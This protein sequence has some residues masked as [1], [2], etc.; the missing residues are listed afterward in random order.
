MRQTITT[1]SAL[2]LSVGILLTGS[3]LQ[4]TLLAVRGNLE[5]FPPSMIG[6]MMSGYFA[7]F[8]AGCVVGPLIVRRV[9][10]I[11]A[12]SVF[13]AI[14]ASVI[15]LHALVVDP[16]VWTGLRVI[17]GISLAGL[18]MI[19]ESWLNERSPNELRGSV[20][21]I[22]RIV[23]LTATTGGLL[24]LTLGDPEDYP[25][26]CLGAIL[27]CLALVPVGLTRS[28][29]PAP[30]STVKIRIGRLYRLSPLGVVGCFGFGVVSGAF[31]GMGPVF[32]QAGGVPLSGVAIFMAAVMIGG[33]LAQ[34]PVGWL[35][36]RY[37]R[38]TILAGTVF[39]ASLS[40]LILIGLYGMPP[41][42]LLVGSA[43]FG[44]LMIPVYSL[45]IS[46]ANDYMEPGDFVEASS[47]LLLLNG[48]GAVVGPLV[49]SILMEATDARAL[50]AFTA[51]V[52]AAMGGFALYRM[53]RRPPKPAEEQGDFIAVPR[54]TPAV[55]QLDPRAEEEQPEGET[56]ASAPASAP[57]ASAPGASSSDESDPSDETQR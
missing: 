48:A 13:A 32:A 22:Y 15:L 5:G 12:F 55:F 33:A 57:G 8:I 31:W 10:H 51:L 45:C 16:Y 19:I 18:Y 11:R 40:G 47:G 2:L 42:F 3:G 37:D 41:Q 44:A 4:G 56:M 27:I 17:S 38:R 9:G 23:D 29:V 46:H 7:G 52:H 6:M 26:F 1:L 28:A 25:L 53:T 34:W 14:A 43:L 50:F 54:S 36:D 39:L 49:A 30:I 20:I 24:L 35:S 21:S